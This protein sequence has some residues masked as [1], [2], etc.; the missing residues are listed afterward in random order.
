M[1]APVSV[2]LL[3][4]RVLR[5]LRLLGLR[6]PAAPW[7]PL[8]NIW[9]APASSPSQAEREGPG[10]SAG[11]GR[12]GSTTA[13]C[14]PCLKICSLGR[15][16]SGLR[17]RPHSNSQCLQGGPSSCGGSETRSRDRCAPGWI[18]A[19]QGGEGAPEPSPS[20]PETHAV[21]GACSAS[22]LAWP[23]GLCDWASH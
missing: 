13:A 22:P 20:R 21:W 8:P 17:A 16:A 1:R 18:S 11:R 15:P 9:K 19:A 23:A 4:M 12:K 2:P 7:P 5:A 3:R 6:G 14:V 10:P